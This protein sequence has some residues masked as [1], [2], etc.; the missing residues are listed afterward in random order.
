M[1][2]RA[3]L[4]RLVLGTEGSIGA[5]VMA[6]DGIPVESFSRGDGEPDIVLYGAEVASLLGSVRGPRA[7]S[8]SSGPIQEL[9]LYG[10]RF[11]AVV[12]FLSDDY[13]VALALQP[14]G[15]MGKARFLVRTALPDLVSEL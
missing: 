3:S 13:F 6:M 1:S 11:N 4:E 5:L 14:G 8:L 7:V 2:F 9:D 10:D 12:R 15:N